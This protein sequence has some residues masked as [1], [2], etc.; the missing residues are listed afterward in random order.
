MATGSNDLFFDIYTDRIS[1]L[2]ADLNIRVEKVSSVKGASDAEQILKFDI[3]ELS[4]GIFSSLQFTISLIGDHHLNPSERI[5][6]QVDYNETQLPTKT[7]SE[8][9]LTRKEDREGNDAFDRCLTDATQE[10]ILPLL[11]RSDYSA[12]ELEQI[13]KSLVLP[14]SWTARVWDTGFNDLIEIVHLNTEQVIARYRFYRRKM[15]PSRMSLLVGRDPLYLQNCPARYLVYGWS[16]DS[17]INDYARIF[18]IWGDHILEDSFKW[19]SDF[20]DSPKELE[21]WGRFTQQR[22]RT[23]VP[24]VSWFEKLTMPEITAYP[25]IDKDFLSRRLQ[26]YRSGE[27]WDD[28]GR[29]GL[30]R[31]MGEPLDD[32]LD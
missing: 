3:R 5:S 2:L 12:E 18:L 13:I 6:L 28:Y 7:V 14:R 19:L 32:D 24:R 21:D 8:S 16:N 22:L 31:F 9:F 30:R 23:G 20:C 27:L 29:M 15:Y 4:K 25:R 10:F 26:S 11:T 17:K 1:W